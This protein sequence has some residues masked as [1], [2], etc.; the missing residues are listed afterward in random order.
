MAPIVVAALALFIRLSPWGLAM[1]ATAENAES[2][3]LSGVW[4]R[5]TSTVAWTI[6]G[7]LSA[8]TAVLA[9]PGQTSA[10]TEVLS[11]GL[12]LLALLAAIL[13]AMFSLPVAFIAGIGV[14]VVQ[15]VL[16]WNITNP[17]SGS[18]TVELIL[19]V[20]LL[21][22]LLVRAAS[23]QKGVRIFERSSW[24][25]GTASF[26]LRTEGLRRRVGF[27]GWGRSS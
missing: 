26:R 19:F 23:L 15:E 22:A 25:M 2:A 5:R 9:S 3:R 7:I 27:S 21:L 17:T 14:G 4:V 10:L 8:V 11:P 24:A 1:R 12:L 6:A 18:A 16:Q 20:L 13:G